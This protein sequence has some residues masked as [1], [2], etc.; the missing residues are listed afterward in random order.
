LVE[1]VGQGAF[2]EVYRAWDSTLQREVALKLLLKRSGD[3]S[4]SRAILREARSLARVR[5]PNVVPVY[6]V[7]RH[8]G[9]VGFWS[10]FVKGKT[11][12]ALLGN[13]VRTER[14]KRLLLV[15]S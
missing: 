15:W 2:G 10:D 12:S 1:K 7:D 3:D 6:G 14:R 9:R 4:D 8:D 11:L 5:H 13:T